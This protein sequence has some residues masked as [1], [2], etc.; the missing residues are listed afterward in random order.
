MMKNNATTDVIIGTSPITQIEF[1][2]WADAIMG[3]TPS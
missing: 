3:T 2:A 1:A